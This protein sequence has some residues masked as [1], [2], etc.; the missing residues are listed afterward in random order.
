MIF[1][2]YLTDLID[3]EVGKL[4]NDGLP[5]WAFFMD[6]FLDYIF[7][8]AIIIGYGFIIPSGFNSTL[9]IF[10]IILSSIMVNIFL[11]FGAT[12]EFRIAYLGI[13]PT[14]TQLFLVIINTFIIF[15]GTN[16]LIKILP[17]VTVLGFL[18]MCFVFYKTHKALWRT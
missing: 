4:T 10:F 9:F 16:F 11:N 17:F 18:F 8:C 1:F 2:H 14:E 3:G 12:N 5:K 13:G 15:L 7:L 6:H